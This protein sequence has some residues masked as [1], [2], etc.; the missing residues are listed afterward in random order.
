VNVPHGNLSGASPSVSAVVP[1]YNR[2]VLVAECVQAILN[3]SAFVSQVVVLDNASTDG[4]RDY[5]QEHGLLENERVDYVAS[6]VNTGSAGG[7]HA[8]LERALLFETDWI[9]MIDNDAIPNPTAL[10]ALLSEAAKSSSKLA[11]FC[12]YQLQLEGQPIT[13]SLPKNVIDAFRFGF[14]CPYINVSLEDSD[15]VQVDWFPFVSALL[16]RTAVINEGLPMA[17]LFYYGEDLEYSLR[18][19]SAGFSAFLVPSSVVD[20]DKP[21]LGRSEKIAGWRWYYLY[22]NTLYVI[23]TQGHQVG[24]GRRIAALARMTIGAAFRIARELVAGDRETATLTYRGVIDGYR[25]QLGPKLA[26]VSS[27]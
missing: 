25:G 19:R 12:S 27:D 5:F 23:R 26:P 21:R 15:A 7:F 9:W 8:G 6:N 18:L 13:Y 16:P 3:Q 24:F 17:E 10:E 2:K 22:R 11:A 14:G 1:T 20:H 4:T